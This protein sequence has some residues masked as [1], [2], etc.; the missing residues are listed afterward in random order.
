MKKSDYVRKRV[1][2]GKSKQQKWQKWK[3]NRKV[4]QVPASLI[5]PTIETQNSGTLS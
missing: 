1:N 4:L 2:N 5:P 3:Q